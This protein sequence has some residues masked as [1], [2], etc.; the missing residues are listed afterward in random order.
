MQSA[1][2]AKLLK[3]ATRLLCWKDKANTKYLAAK[4]LKYP[5]DG[6]NLQKRINLNS[7]P[8]D[9]KLLEKEVGKDH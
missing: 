7:E 5:E 2:K 1:E 6:H 8:L 9:F 3:D 4:S